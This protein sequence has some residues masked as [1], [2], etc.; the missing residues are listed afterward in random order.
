MTPCNRRFGLAV[1]TLAGLL[2]LQASW[3]G[4]LTLTLRSGTPVPTQ[5]DPSITYLVEPSGACG[6][7]FPAAFGPADFAAAVGGP[8]AWSVPAYPVWNQ[9]LKCDPAANWVSTSAGLPSRSALYA[10]Q[11]VIQDPCCIKSATLDFCWSVDDF[12]G[13]PT[14]PNPAGVYLNGI[15]L[16]SISGGNYLTESQ[17]SGVDITKLVHCGTN[18]LYVYDRDAGCAVAGVRFSATLQINKCDTPVQSTTWG[19]LKTLYH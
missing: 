15:P 12:L 3:A 2:T 1:C 16:P 18:T 19:R 5:V 10:I 17:V 13:D 7:G 9:G 6:V 11:F 4:A 14:G 8:N